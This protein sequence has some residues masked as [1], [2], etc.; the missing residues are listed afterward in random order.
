MNKLIFAINLMDHITA[1]ILTGRTYKPL[2]RFFFKIIYHME[3]IPLITPEEPYGE[4]SSVVSQLPLIFRFKGTV[5]ISTWWQILLV[6][7]YTAVIVYVHEE[8]EGIKINF[9]QALID[10]LGIVTGL[11]LAFRTNTAYE[12]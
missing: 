12:R 5:I 6:T 3:K 8:V 4:S 9:S 10:I 2:E 7:I 1:N 11:L